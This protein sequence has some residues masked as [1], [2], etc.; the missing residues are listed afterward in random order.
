MASYTPLL[1]HKRNQKASTDFAKWCWML[2]VPMR[3]H[4]Q[5]CVK[6]QS[7]Q[8]LIHTKSGLHIKK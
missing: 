4:Q 8:L 7:N 1:K 2:F 3:R 6:V 5:R